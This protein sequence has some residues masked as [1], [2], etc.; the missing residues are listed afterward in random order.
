MSY[1]FQII[2]PQ[3]L[4]SYAPK[5]NPDFHAKKEAENALNQAIWKY[6][7]LYYGLQHLIYNFSEYKDVFQEAV[8]FGELVEFKL[9][10]GNRAQNGAYTKDEINWVEVNKYMKTRFYNRF[11]EAFSLEQIEGLKS[12]KQIVKAQ[13]ELIMFA[14]L[15][16]G[17]HLLGNKFEQVRSIEENKKP[18]LFY[19]GDIK[20]SVRASA[21]TRRIVIDTSDLAIPE[22]IVMQRLFDDGWRSKITFDS[23]GITELNGSQACTFSKMMEI[24]ARINAN[25]Q[26]FFNNPEGFLQIESHELIK[27]NLSLITQK[28]LE[29]NQAQWERRKANQ[30]EQVAQ[31]RLNE[32]TVA[33]EQAQEAYEQGEISPEELEEIS[34]Q[35]D[36]VIANENPKIEDKPQNG[37]V[38]VKF[39]NKAK[40]RSSQEAEAWLA[41]HPEFAQDLDGELGLSEIENPESEDLA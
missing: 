9:A 32:V 1:Q 8:S 33:A 24:A 37:K 14:Y 21:K 39:S 23:M 31:V 25:M 5:L 38:V 36:M 19:D 20:I 35:T 27:R 11:K 10:P 13:E 34:H 26:D 16:L 7:N 2:N 22:I 12:Y 17:E 6:K 41:A 15:E 18:Y 30:K 29:I 28:L 4:G 40:R 3:V